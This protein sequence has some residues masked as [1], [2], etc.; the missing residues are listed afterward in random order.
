M[1]CCCIILKIFYL[2]T[3]WNLYLICCTDQL[4]FRLIG[5]VK[6]YRHNLPVTAHCWQNQRRSDKNIKIYSVSPKKR[7]FSPYHRL[8]KDPFYV[9]T[10]YIHLLRSYK[11]FLPAFII[12]FAQ[13]TP[14]GQEVPHQPPVPVVSCI[15]ERAPGRVVPAVHVIPE[16]LDKGEY[17]ESKNEL[18]PLVLFGSVSG[19]D[20]P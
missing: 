11:K 15:H 1:F 8:V 19:E 14:P 5:L 10:L 2:F 17:F 12:C 13:V 20:S 16:L 4:W 9:E 3:F 6:N 18:A 7:S